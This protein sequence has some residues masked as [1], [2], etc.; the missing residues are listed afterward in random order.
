[1]QRSRKPALRVGQLWV[2]DGEVVR[3][4]AW[5][6]DGGGSGI[7]T[8][9]NPENPDETLSMFGREFREISNPAPNL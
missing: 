1:V 5:G 2:L 6:Q 4:T 3:I 7:V 9:V 8:F